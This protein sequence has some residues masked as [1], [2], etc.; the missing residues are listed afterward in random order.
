MVQLV[1]VWLSLH[2]CVFASV[3]GLLFG[4]PH[5][6]PQLLLA[7]TI[8]VILLYGLCLYMELKTPQGSRMPL[9][10]F[11]LMNYSFHIL[12]M[13]IILFLLKSNS[14]QWFIS[15]GFA[16]FFQII[17]FLS[18]KFGNRNNFFTNII[19]K[20]NYFF[21]NPQAPMAQQLLV[22]FEIMTLITLGAGKSPGQRV[23]DR[24]IYVGWFLMYRYATDNTHRLVWNAISTSISRFGMKCP[25][26]LNIILQ[27]L[28]QTLSPLG[29]L[30]FKIYL[31]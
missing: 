28:S 30:S 13:Q 17:S 2:I 25:Q 20:I 11:L 12:T 15:L 26:F 18:Q 31:H 8:S 27:K 1:Y 21:T 22:I 23:L 3:V 7:E 10:Q 9:R 24:I 6:T 5:P 29:T 4:G 14:F 16:S 19:L